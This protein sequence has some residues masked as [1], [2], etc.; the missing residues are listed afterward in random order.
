MVSPVIKSPL[1]GNIGV[2]TGV[3]YRLN[4]AGT[5]VASLLALAN[6][7][8]PQKMGLDIV[9]SE[10]GDITYT[11]TDHA[12][13]DRGTATS[14]TFKQLETLTI[15][16]TLISSIDI[17]FVGSIGVPGIPGGFGGGL[18]ADLLKLEIIK[19][20]A[21]EQE[22]IM[23][24]SP[25]RTMGLAFITGISDT[26]SPDDGENTMVSISLKEARI[27]SPLNADGLVQDLASM[28]TGNNATAGLGGQAP[29][30]VLT[31]SIQGS[32][33]P[34]VAPLVVPVF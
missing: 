16:G 13:Q 24:V 15:A 20:I 1:G 11:T 21:D 19:A 28:A 4:A 26:W 2:R 8:S 3:F 29:S 18:R 17:P 6:P 27:V 33:V 22:P 9:D 23:Y 31:Q 12:L 30:P 32:T 5:P 14:N 34:G 25:R 7:F 10:S